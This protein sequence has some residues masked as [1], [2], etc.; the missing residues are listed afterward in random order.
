VQWTTVNEK[1][2]HEQDCKMWFREA[3]ASRRTKTTLIKSIFVSPRISHQGYEVR[4][5]DMRTFFVNGRQ[6]LDLPSH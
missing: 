6:Q 5:E 4:H 1:L 3:G 2:P